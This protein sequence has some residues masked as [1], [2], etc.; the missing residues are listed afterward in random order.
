MTYIK[1]SFSARLKDLRRL[2]R[3]RMEI[4]IDP[5]VP[6]YYQS[7][8][9]RKNEEPTDDSALYRFRIRYIDPARSRRKK[10]C[11][12]YVF[13]SILTFFAVR[14]IEFNDV[15]IAVWRFCEKGPGP[16]YIVPTNCQFPITEKDRE[17]ARFHLDEV[18]RAI[19]YT[20]LVRIPK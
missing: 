19:L 6:G 2:R 15:N 3:I 12:K 16:A 20:Y 1:K 11:K 14:K 4:R 8:R 10:D 7:E 18:H 9:L 5:G 17:R 13:L